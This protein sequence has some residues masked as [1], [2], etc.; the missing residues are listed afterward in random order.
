MTSGRKCARV[1]QTDSSPDDDMWDDVSF[2]H[3]V[4]YE[5]NGDDLCVS[6]THYVTLSNCIS[7]LLGFSV[8]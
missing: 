7:N 6:E 4:R 3:V 2:A 1:A 5:D 8:I